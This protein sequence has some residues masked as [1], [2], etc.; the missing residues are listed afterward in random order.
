DGAALAKHLEQA[1][2]QPPHVVLAEGR[3]VALPPVEQQEHPRKPVRARSRRP[4]LGEPGEALRGEQLLAARDLVAELAEQPLH[5][6]GLGGRSVSPEG[7]GWTSASPPGP[8]TWAGAAAGSSPSVTISGRGSSQGLRCW[9]SPALT[10]AAAIASTSTDRSVSI[11]SSSAPAARPVTLP[12]TAPGAGSARPRPRQGTGM[13]W[14]LAVT[15]PVPGR[16]PPM[17]ADWTA[18][19]FEAPERAAPAGDVDEPVDEVRQFRDHGRE[20][21]DDQH[22]PRHRRQVQ[23]GP[24]PLGVPV[25]FDVLRAR[26]QQHLLAPLELGAE[27]VERADGQVTV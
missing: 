19:R 13:T 5:P 25:V 21:V 20:L 26:V 1:L 15:G 10:L 12:G 4:L 3:V 16:R 6:A 9:P 7:I 24:E 17:R 11:V 27:R 18:T 2:D 14:A 22:E 8:G 23:L